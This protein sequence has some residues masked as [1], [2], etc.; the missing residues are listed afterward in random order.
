MR[1]AT[2]KELLLIHDTTVSIHAP[3]ARCDTYGLWKLR[4]LLQFQSTHLMRGATCFRLSVDS[5][6]KFQSTHLMRGATPR[7][8]FKVFYIFRFNPRTSCEVRLHIL[9]NI[10]HTSQEVDIYKK[11]KY[12]FILNYNFSEKIYR[13]PNYLLKSF[14]VRSKQS[15]HPHYYIQD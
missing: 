13:E 11:N 9:Y 10:K 2:Q 6:L 3:H 15:T 7:L 12:F 5:R 8:I 14:W 1:G 4:T